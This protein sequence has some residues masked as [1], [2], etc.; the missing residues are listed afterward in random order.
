MNAAVGHTIRQ[1]SLVIC[2]LKR[3]KTGLMPILTVTNLHQELLCLRSIHLRATILF[4]HCCLLVLLS[5]G[6]VDLETIQ[7]RPDGSGQM[8]LLGRGGAANFGFISITYHQYIFGLCKYIL[9][10]EISIFYRENAK[11]RPKFRLIMCFWDIQSGGGISTNVGYREIFSF[12]N[13][14]IS[15]IDI[16]IVS[17]DVKTC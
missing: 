5:S 4:H 15:P 2:L 17:Y 13:I 3:K 8:D 6:S 11:N 16:L 10:L 1:Q 9:R 7:A 12:S 14:L